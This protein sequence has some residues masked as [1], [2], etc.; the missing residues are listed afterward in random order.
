MYECLARAKFGG[1]TTKS[2]YARQ[3]ATII[4]MA[5]TES[6]ITTKVSEDVW[7]NLWVITEFG[8]AYMKEIEKDVIS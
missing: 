5:A 8:N 1:F 3:A 4:A 6:L 7:G 2:A